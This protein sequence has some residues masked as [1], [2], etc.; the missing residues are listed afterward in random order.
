VT[1]SAAR[2]AGAVAVLACA[3]LAV[4]LVVGPE[5]SPHLA[6]FAAALV[7]RAL[8]VFIVLFVVTIIVVAVRA[9]RRS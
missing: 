1:T 5:H 2:A 4:L 7:D 6:R 9:L 3:A 8:A